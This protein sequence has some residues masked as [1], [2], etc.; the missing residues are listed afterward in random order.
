MEKKERLGKCKVSCSRSSKLVRVRARPD[1]AIWHTP[2][3]KEG[4]G[5]ESRGQTDG[6]TDVR[7]AFT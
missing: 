6:Q 5:W 3:R 1:L 2:S 4:S 7:A